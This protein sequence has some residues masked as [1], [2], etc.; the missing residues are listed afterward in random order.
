[1]PPGLSALGIHGVSKRYDATR[2]LDDVSF[3]VGRARVHALVGGNGSGKST[4][5]KVLA[6]AVRA[7]PGG[8]LVVGSDT[9]VLDT[10]DVA[11]SRDLGL[12]FV[13]QDL[14]LFP[15]LSVSE[16]LAVGFGFPTGLAGHVRRRELRAS[17]LQVLDRFEI[18]AGPD[19]LV[20]WLRPATRTMVAVARALQDCKGDERRVLVLDEPTAALAR[21]EV[22]LLHGHVR[23]LRDQG[24]AV[25]VVSHRLGEVFEIADDVTVLRD[26]AHV[27]T[28][29]VAEIDEAE[30]TLLITGGPHRFA[31]A[32]S[33]DSPAPAAPVALPDSSAPSAPSP[34][35]AV[36]LAV[37]HLGGGRIRDAS[38]Q[39]RA[40]EI[41]GL[42]GLVGSGRTELFDLL[43]GATRPTTG[44]IEVNGERVTFGHPHDAIAAGI[45]RVPEDRLVDGTFPDR[46]VAENLSAGRVRRF[47]KFPIVRRGDELRDAR[48][49]IEG[50]LRIKVSGP[51]APL[52]TLSGGNQ[53]K[54]VVGRSLATEPT[55]LL[56][57]EPTQG[58]DVG[59]RSEL[60]ER[61]R[62]EADRGMAVLV[63][64]SDFNEL[65]S[66]VDRV[67]VL[68]D[69]RIVDEVGGDGLT[70]ERC[71]QLVHTADASVVD[72][73]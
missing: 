33:S 25:M 64:S 10:F 69:G 47:F 28:R 30:L 12:R 40:G 67:L 16:N 39:L 26:G 54:V 43:A 6:G 18:D 41:V 2:A 68:R 46:T 57:D 1:M 4:L 15:D 24:H 21:T 5:I 11:R 9:V 73:E 58:V 14:G 66:L 27:A 55:I 53:Q 23:R 63:A 17:T 45:S 38:L 44:I 50:P 29:R 13:H 20:G 52:W 49:I 34:G 42:A 48:H 36:A 19:E 62:A 59:A 65:A 31:S 70:P 51:T 71:W 72:D 3:D 61:F 22:S 60:H 32:D 8:E 7:D 56:L 37:D 35:G